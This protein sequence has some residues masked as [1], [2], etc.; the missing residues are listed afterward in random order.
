[1]HSILGVA[2]RLRYAG[3]LRAGLWPAAMM[4]ELRLDSLFKRLELRPQQQEASMS[5]PSFP[6]A[7]SGY[8]APSSR[9]HVVA[10]PASAAACLIWEA[11]SVDVRWRPPLSVV[12]VTHLVTR[13]RATA[14]R[15]R[16]F[17]WRAAWRSTGASMPVLDHI[18][19]PSE[20]TALSRRRSW[21]VLSS[22]QEAK[23][24]K[25]PRI[26]LLS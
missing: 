12:I 13:P 22:R 26:N 1:M 20:P 10:R 8:T 24:Y 16:S 7:S 14:R 6:Q 2:Y 3:G 19:A 15:P 11:P 21:L 25:E 4:S 18:T 5:R 17:G 23:S 9:S